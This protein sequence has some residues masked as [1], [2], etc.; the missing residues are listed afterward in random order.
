MTRSLKAT[1]MT[2]SGT[3]DSYG[4]A[5]G[6]QPGLLVRPSSV[7][8]QYS[9]EELAKACDGFSPSRL[10]GKGGAAE[11][12]RGEIAGGQKVAIKMM[13]GA[14]FSETRFRQFQAELDVL[15][16]LRHMHLCS[17]IGYAAHQSRS[18]IVYP[19]V[20]GGTLYDCLHGAPPEPNPGD[21]DARPERG[22][23]S[24]K[25]RLSIA[26]QVAKALRHLHEEVDPPVIHRDVKSKNVVLE[27]GG[28]GDSAKI[29]AY[30]S[31][32]GLAKLGQSAFS[33][34]TPPLLAGAQQPPGNMTNIDLVTFDTPEHT[35]TWSGDTIHTLNVAGTWGYMAPE[36]MR[37]CWL[38]YKNDVYA[39][40]VILLELVTRRK[41]FGRMDVL[42][43]Q[44]QDARNGAEGI[45]QTLTYWA[46]RTLR[47][48][49]CL[50]SS[51]EEE[52]SRTYRGTGV[53]PTVRSRRKRPYSMKINGVQ[54]LADPQLESL[55]MART[56]TSLRSKAST[57]RVYSTKM[58]G[59]QELADPQLESI[60]PPC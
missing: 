27:Y 23:L 48:L 50:S 31:D 15:A 17:I 3:G 52:G 38:T 29:R 55:C 60:G 6:G 43:E 44:Q 37:S 26:R 28:H 54:E 33:S 58:N 32:F 1:E 13:K 11:V 25:A 39:F 5:A 12:Y 21:G 19:F 53:A 45:P 18:F 40:G 34:S 46:K 4:S 49:E 35:V 24:W 47:G 56:R 22:P 36:Y 20:E 59:V 14:E 51:D 2:S 8:K 16:T 42:P 57:K 30:L 41:A 9:W 10:V 7:L